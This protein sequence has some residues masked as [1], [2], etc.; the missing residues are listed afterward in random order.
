MNRN[1]RRG[2]GTL[3][4]V[5]VLI[6]AFVGCGRSDSRSTPSAPSAVQQP[7]NPNQPV[8]FKDPLTGLSISDVRDAQDH[9]VQFTTARE[10]VWIDGTHLPGHS[11]LGPGESFFNLAEEPSCQCWL[12]V[13]FGA[14]HGERRAYL[15]ADY[16]HFNP[17]T[18]VALEIAGGKLMVSRTD[19]FPP[20]TYSLSGI[21]TEATETGL[22]PIENVG[23]YRLNQEGGGWDETMT[24]DNGFYEIRGLT[25][26]SRLT[27]FSKNGYQKVEQADFS[28]HCDMRFDVQLIRR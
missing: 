11:A 18:V 26:G 19:V 15:T 4:C 23:V 6:Q 21:V 20:G 7:V 10:L 8:S 25:D 22:T 14:S 24:D 3:V 1:S 16:I 5:C 12:V 27:G 13:H 17:R 28:I 9:I 2:L